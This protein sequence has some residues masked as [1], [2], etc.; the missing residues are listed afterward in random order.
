MKKHKHDALIREWL[1]N[2]MPSVQVDNSG[3][4]EHV[5]TPMW[6]VNRNYRL[7]YPPKPKKQIQM[8]C[9]YDNVTSRLVWASEFSPVSGDWIHVPAEDKVIEV[10][11]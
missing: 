2:G 5:V 9:W 6:Y 11:E 4:W 10:E 3:V 7:A 8:L 1:D